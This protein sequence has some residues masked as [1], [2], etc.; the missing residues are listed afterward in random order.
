MNEVTTTMKT[1]ERDAMREL[2]AE[3][4]AGIAGVVTAS[5]T[6]GHRVHARRLAGAWA[7]LT[8]ALA[9]EPAPKLRPCPHC[10]H[11]VM[12]AATRCMHCWKRSSQDGIPA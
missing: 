11:S 3:V 12:L 1:E 7:R 6:E 10:R 5:S 9:P 4:D 2:L 8:R